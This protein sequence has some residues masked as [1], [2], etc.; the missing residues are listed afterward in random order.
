MLALCVLSLPFATILFSSF[1]LL[2]FLA[3]ISLFSFNLFFYHFFSFFFILSL[4][5]HFF[6]NSLFFF[7]FL[8]SPVSFSLIC[9][10]AVSYFFLCHTWLFERNFSNQPFLLIVFIFPECTR[11]RVKNHTYKYKGLYKLT[12][13]GQCDLSIHSID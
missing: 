11:M 4:F 9:F 8:N 10:L 5:F 12:K 2:Y 1:T 13:K 3:S 7:F 6:S